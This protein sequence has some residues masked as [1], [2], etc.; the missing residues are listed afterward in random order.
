MQDTGVQYLRGW[1]AAHVSVKGYIHLA[2]KV[3]LDDR[4]TSLCSSYVEAFMTEEKY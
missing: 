4:P 3:E 2:H 1:A